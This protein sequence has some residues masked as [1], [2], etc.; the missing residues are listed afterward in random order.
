MIS[1]SD[2]FLLL[3]KWMEE[4]HPLKLLIAGEGFR[5]SVAGRI[6]E[7]EGTRLAFLP[8]E[9]NP[10][11]AESVLEL[12]NCRFEYGDSREAPAGS[13][14]GLVLSAILTVLRPDGTAFMFAERRL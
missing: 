5:I 2:G 9:P 6:A 8:D 13:T 3:N 4:R 7:I 1:D 11:E 10:C 12:A 14:S